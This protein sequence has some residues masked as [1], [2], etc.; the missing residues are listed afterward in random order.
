MPC[1]LRSFCCSRCLSLLPASLAGSLMLPCSFGL[2]LSRLLDRPSLSRLLRRDLWRRLLSAPRSKSAH[3][4]HRRRSKA[5]L[6]VSCCMSHINSL[7]LLSL[8]SA[9]MTLHACNMSSKRQCSMSHQQRV[10]SHPRLSAD[11]DRGLLPAFQRHWHCLH[12]QLM[13]HNAI[14]LGGERDLP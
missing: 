6:V 2:S 14:Q 3:S 11:A 13:Q 8:P 7:H 10:V 5:C 1:S 12:M 4:S 9:E